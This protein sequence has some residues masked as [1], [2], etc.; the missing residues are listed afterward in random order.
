[1]LLF[2][3]FIK[4]LADLKIFGF[5]FGVACG[6]LILLCEAHVGVVLVWDFLIHFG[7]TVKI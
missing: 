5:L 6:P 3:V 2:L 7:K 1:M 4:T